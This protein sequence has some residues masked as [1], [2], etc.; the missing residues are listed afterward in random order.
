MG[1]PKAFLEWNGV[2]LWL[3]RVRMLLELGPAEL[4]ISAPANL[5]IEPGPWTLVRDR[6]PGLGPLAGIEAAFRAGSA[7]WLVV[8]AV[9]MPAMTAGFLEGLVREAGPLGIVPEHDG[10]FEGLAAVY[11]RSIL[12]LVEEALR[13]ADRSLQRLVDRAVGC[14]LVRPRAVE[15]HE[16]ALFHNLN[17]PADLHASSSRASP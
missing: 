4:M 11:P 17:R 15:G 1:R 8:L 14:G 16:R 10:F 3:D 9:D 13:G 7:D 2:A 5:P 6:T 12:P